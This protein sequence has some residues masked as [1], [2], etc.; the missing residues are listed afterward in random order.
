LRAFERV[1]LRRLKGRG[2]LVGL[3]GKAALVAVLLLATPLA[4]ARVT[5]GPL[6]KSPYGGSNFQ[7]SSWTSGGCGYT[8]STLKTPVF[9]LSTGVFVGAVKSGTASCGTAPNHVSTYMEGG[10][11][12]SATFTV[13]SG[14]RHLVVHWSVSVNVNLKATPGGLTPSASSS[15]SVW[16]VSLLYDVTNGSYHYAMY[17]QAFYN[18]TTSGTVT[19]H[20]SRALVADINATLTSTHT[21]YLELYIEGNAYAFAGP[22]T[23]SASASLNLGTGGDQAKLNSVTIT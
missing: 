1:A 23:N 13:T 21:Y 16:L 2:R 12:P 17:S 6:L 5:H 15:T 20:G 14:M 18:Y 4:G 11:A 19:W 22:G 10:L 3:S 8:S 9:S 7:G